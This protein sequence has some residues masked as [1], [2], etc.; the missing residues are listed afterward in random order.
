VDPAGDAWNNDE[1]E[2]SLRDIR[3]TMTAYKPS[4]W[5]ALVGREPRAAETLA[6]VRALDDAF[7]GVHF[8][9]DVPTDGGRGLGVRWAFSSVSLARG[10][11]RR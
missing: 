7:P 3:I 2:S 1:Y 6:A 9:E 10:G 8:Y 4:A 5:P 11:G